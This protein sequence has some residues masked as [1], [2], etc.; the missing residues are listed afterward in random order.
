MH[1][2]HAHLK[3]KYTFYW[4]IHCVLRLVESLTER[5]PMCI[6]WHN[7]HTSHDNTS[8]FFIISMALRLFSSKI[9]KV[10]DMCSQ[11]HD[12]TSE[13]RCMQTFHIAIS[14]GIVYTKYL[15]Q[16]SMFCIIL[17]MHHNTLL[18]QMDTFALHP[19]MTNS[20]FSRAVSFHFH[21]DGS[22]RSGN[23]I[24]CYLIPRREFKC[25]AIINYSTGI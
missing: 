19:Q 13:I 18:I 8:V 22:R 7:Q 21:L 1:L 4:N 23:R 16:S 17:S 11:W 12:K 24:T 20:I 15:M 2:K 5:S 10:L 25:I 14:Y 6:N 3:C 9:Y